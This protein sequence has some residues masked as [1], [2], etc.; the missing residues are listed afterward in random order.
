MIPHPSAPHNAPSLR[1]L[2]TETPQHSTNLPNPRSFSHTTARLLLLSLLLVL[3][4]FSACGGTAEQLLSA[5][6]FQ[7]SSYPL[8]KTLQNDSSLIIRH[9]PDRGT[10]I[11][12]NSGL[13]YITGQGL[14]QNDIESVLAMAPWQS[15]YLLIAR[16]DKLQIWD[17]AFHE[18]DIYRKLNGEKITALAA[19]DKEV[20]WIGTLSN[21]W[22]IK[23]TE[24]R[25]FSQLA[26]PQALYAFQGAHS[27]IVHTKEGSYKALSVAENGDVK[28]EDFSSTSNAPEIAVA[29]KGGQIWGLAEG[30]LYQWT[31][32]GSQNAWTPFGW[33]AKTKEGSPLKINQLALDALTGKLWAVT[34]GDLFQISPTRVFRIERPAGIG[35]IRFVQAA[36]DALWLMDDKNLHRMSVATG[37][38]EVRYTGRIKTFMDA[39]CLRCHGATGPGRNLDS[40]ASTKDI[41]TRIAEV[42]EGGQMPPDKSTLVGGDAN[43]IRRWIE[44]GSKE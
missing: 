19:Q 37:S 15:N 17:G 9:I 1:S 43:L 29:G 6:E 44:G 42:I 26:A 2:R 27:V 13:Y 12:A 22:L 24:A 41:A 20:L 28:M 16:P 11:G 38:E 10:L 21:L 35:T 31:Q 32:Q 30:L 14:L 23:G 40:Y 33:T 5:S 3:P 39:N 8:P 36:E 34:D 7:V 25:A 18:S 4:A